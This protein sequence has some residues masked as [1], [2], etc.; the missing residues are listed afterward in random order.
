MKKNLLIALFAVAGIAPLAAQ[1][2]A[3]TESYVSVHAGRSEQ[4]LTIEDS[5]TLT[6]SGTGYRLAIGSK[7]SN[8]FGIEAGYVKQAKGTL[9]TLVGTATSDP[10]SLYLAAT[11]TFPVSDRFALTGKLG[12]IRHSTEFTFGGLT[13]KYR[14]TAPMGGVGMLFSINP[15]LTATLEY[16]NYGKL[17]DEDG[18]KIEGNMVSAG[19]RFNF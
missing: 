10:K 13:D 4:K 18:A 12:A 16:E 7:F 15:A 14:E 9:D 3:E 17:F 6:D 8:N 1:A 2:Q 19:L 11:G 5:F